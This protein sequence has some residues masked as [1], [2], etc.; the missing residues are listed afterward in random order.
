MIIT[1]PRLSLPFMKTDFSAKSRWHDALRDWLHM[2]MTGWQVLGRTLLAYL[3]VS[4]WLGLLGFFASIAETLCEKQSSS[5][6]VVGGLFVFFGVF[7]YL[8]LTFYVAASWVGFCPRVEDA[9]DV[10]AHS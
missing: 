4:L 1:V 8:P 10:Q 5:W 3:I 7:V 2:W 6:Y 9:D